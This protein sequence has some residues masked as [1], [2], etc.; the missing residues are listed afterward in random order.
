MMVADPGP[1][2]NMAGITT[3]IAI[4]GGPV[5]MLSLLPEIIIDYHTIIIP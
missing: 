2:Q 4:R 1:G 3:A 5:A